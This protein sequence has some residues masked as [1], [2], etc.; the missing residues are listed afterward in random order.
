MVCILLINITIL[1]LLPEKTEKCYLMFATK[2]KLWNII[3]FACLLRSKPIFI[4][5]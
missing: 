5:A 4:E 1:H 3:S 2:E